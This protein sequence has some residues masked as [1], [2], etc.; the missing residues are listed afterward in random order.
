MSDDE[1]VTKWRCARCR[2]TFEDAYDADQHSMKTGHPGVRE[3][4]ADPTPDTEPTTI[5]DF[6]QED[7]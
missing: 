1:T 2:R 6:D 4:E 3:I 7:Q 5:Y